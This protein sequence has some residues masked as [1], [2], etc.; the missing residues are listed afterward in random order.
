[1]Y[2][3]PIAEYK[4]P[5]RLPECLELLA[6]HRPET[7]VL[8]GGQSLVPLLKRRAVSAQTIVDINR[9][10]E[11]STLA[12][13]VTEDGQRV[14]RLGALTRHR[15]LAEHPLL[16]TRYPALA[17]AAASIGDVQVRNRGTI[18]GSLVQADPGADLPVVLA[19]L[20][21]TVRLRSLRGER[22]LD[23]EALI[24]DA[25]KT[26]CD[27][28]E[29]VIEV[30]V[31]SPR[32][33]EGAAYLKHCD[34]FHIGVVNLAAFVRL[35]G[36]QIEDVRIV[37][38]GVSGR[39]LRVAAAEQLLLGRQADAHAIAEASDRIGEAFLLPEDIRGSAPYRRAL[40]RAGGARV[41]TRA[42]ARAKG[43]EQG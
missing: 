38:G 33:G 32:R 21:A 13:G 4:A 24:L 14:L 20:G 42:L 29:L 10:Q 22:V 19:A 25:G 12:E 34:V 3:R 15:T 5:V 37:V 26:A 16:G 36:E 43:G 30:D 23:L 35:D 7:R 2:P 27:A 41:L 40:L 1:M 9:V 11:L 28:D 31:P 17:E 18:G 8:A 6:E 39:P